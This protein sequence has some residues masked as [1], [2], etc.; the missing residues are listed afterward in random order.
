MKR[1]DYIPGPADAAIAR[2]D[3]D[4]WTLVLTRQL[5]HT[6]EKVWRALTDPEHLKEWAPFDADASLAHTGAIVRLSTVGAPSEFISATTITRAEAP[7]VLEYGWGGND[8]KWQLEPSSTGTTLTLWAAI[9]KRYIAMGAAGWH[10]CL[11]VLDHLLAGTP[12]GGSVAGD[13]L[14]FPGWQRLHNEYLGLF[15]ETK[16]GELK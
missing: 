4:L 9:D 10:L 15:G 1:D 12:L 8:M 5:R 14:K 6:P 16:K 13:A 7:H 11:D 3:G 2:K